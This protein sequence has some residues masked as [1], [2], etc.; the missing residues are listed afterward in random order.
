MRKLAKIGKIWT[1]IDLET[2]RILSEKFTLT[3]TV[4][5]TITELQLM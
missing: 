1:G 4:P 5:D 3:Q 2:S